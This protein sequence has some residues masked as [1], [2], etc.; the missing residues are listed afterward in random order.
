MAAAAGSRAMVLPGLPQ[1]AVVSAAAM[2]GAAAAR[3]ALVNRLCHGA[4]HTRRHWGS[5][6]TYSSSQPVSGCCRAPCLT[7]WF[8]VCPSLLLPLLLLLQGPGTLDALLGG[9]PRMAGPPGADVSGMVA[10]FEQMQRAAGQV[11]GTRHGSRLDRLRASRCCAPYHACA[12]LP[13]LGPPAFSRL[14]SPPHPGARCPL[15]RSHQ[16]AVQCWPRP[17]QPWHTTSG[18]VS[19]EGPR[20]CC[21][22]HEAMRTTVLHVQPG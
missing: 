14:T 6:T 19:G 3:S 11:G 1:G 18:W 20:N 17:P 16:A 13:G 8:A 22:L 5:G 15:G 2:P 12:P 21:A 10:E 7:R 9:A 4:Y